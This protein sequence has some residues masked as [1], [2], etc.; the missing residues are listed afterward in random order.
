MK[1]RL[2]STAKMAFYTARRRKGDTA[3][4][5]EMTGYSVS[6]ISNIMNGNRSINNNVANAMWDISRRR[7]KTSEL[8]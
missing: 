4:I 2:N 5:A 7:V 8:A 6:H 3:R 1:K